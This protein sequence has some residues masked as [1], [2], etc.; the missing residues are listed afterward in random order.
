M[1]MSSIRPQNITNPYQRIADP[2]K[3]GTISKASDPKTFSESLGKKR[4]VSRPDHLEIN[5]LTRADIQSIIQNKI[6]ELKDKLENGETEPTYQ[7]GS[8]AL[9]KKEWDNLIYKVD[10][11]LEK[12]ENKAENESEEKT[13]TSIKS[14]DQEKKI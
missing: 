11:A 14:K 3:E 1:M 10:S 6:L 2:N 5:A 12:D 9:T 4:Q 8:R 7:I 13:D